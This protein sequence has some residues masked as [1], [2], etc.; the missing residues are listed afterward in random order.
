MILLCLANAKFGS[1][2]VPIWAG[3][4]NVV[5]MDAFDMEYVCPVYFRTVYQYQG[6][7]WGLCTDPP[8]FTATDINGLG[9]C[10][11]CHPGC[12]Y[13]RYPTL[14]GHCTRCSPGYV[15]YPNL[16]DPL[17]DVPRAFGHSCGLDTPCDLGNGFF[18]DW[19]DITCKACDATCLTC[20]DTT[21]TSCLSCAND[22]YLTNNRECLTCDSSCLT[23]SDANT[24]T[25]CNINYRLV[26][27]MCIN[28]SLNHII[29]I[30]VVTEVVTVTQIQTVTIDLNV[31][32]TDLFS[33]IHE[34]Y[35]NTIYENSTL[36]S[37]YNF[38]SNIVYPN[39]QTYVSTKVFN[40]TS[41][42]SSIDVIAPNATTQF[43]T[44]NS[45]Y[46]T[47]FNES[48]T[49]DPE[50]ICVGYATSHTSPY[51]QQITA[52]EN[53]TCQINSQQLAMSCT[54]FLDISLSVITSFIPLNTCSREIEIRNVTYHDNIC[55]GVTWTT[56]TDIPMSSKIL[57][58]ISIVSTSAYT[59]QTEYGS[60]TVSPIDTSSQMTSI[61]LFI[62]NPMFIL[63]ICLICSIFLMFSYI[64]H[65]QKQKINLLIEQMQ[66]VEMN[67]TITDQVLPSKLLH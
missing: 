51:C 9:E 38:T 48:I 60:H 43:N 27:G 24:C 14:V 31:T 58:P 34:Q 54:E 39:C 30:Q 44:V 50:S 47:S 41:I 12:T 64:L 66:N 11:V 10:G 16:E 6:S 8:D 23:C 49:L 19:R 59:M 28:N 32:V 7:C 53:K 15:I 56:N 2:Y 20:S 63:I 17:Q 67:V 55:S 61:W 65:I 1:K 4:L 45:S 36:Y 40:S 57:Q 3:G 46:V 18:R 22:N 37:I 35:Y 13:C 62:S 33:T 21:M 42:Y 5:S 52:V 29:P 26:N 25:G